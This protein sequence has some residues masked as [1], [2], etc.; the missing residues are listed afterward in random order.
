MNRSARIATGG[1]AAAAG[2]IAVTTLASR[3]VGFGRWLVFSSQTGATGVG[4]AYATANQLPNVLYE[5]AAGGALAAVAVPLIARHLNR[6]DERSADATAS[7]LLTWALT[8]LVPL[9]LLLGLAAGPL[10]RVLLSSPQGPTAATRELATMMLVVF[11]PQVALYGI[12]VVFSGILQAHRRFFAAALAPLLS[13]LVVIAAYLLYGRLSAGHNGDPATVPD[14]AAYTLAVGTTLG[15]VA[16]SLPLLIPLR[17]LG[18][19]LRPTWRFPAGVG[20]RA[21]VLAAAGLLAL[22]GQQVAVLVTVWVSNRYGDTG[23]LNVYTY[24]QAVYLLPYGVLAVPLAM[25]AFPRLAADSPASPQHAGAAAERGD[26]GGTP[27]PDLPAETLARSLRALVVAAALGAAVL[28][29]TSGP[30]GAFFRVLDRGRANS[31]SLNALEAMPAALVAYAPGLV[32][33]GTAAL[34][35]RALYVRGRPL[36]AASAVAL[37]WAVA[38]AGPLLLLSGDPGAR[39]T[40]TTLGWSSSAGMTLAGVLLWVLVVRGWGLQATA[41][42]GRAVLAALTGAGL[43]AVTGLTLGA[44]WNPEGLL[45]ALLAG[46]VLAG[47]AVLVCLAAVALVDP[48][49]YRLTTGRLL[50]R[51][52]KGR[53]RG[54]DS[55]P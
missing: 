42:A 26:A 48:A 7:A 13:S 3:L 1:I 22:L 10:S 18:V 19:R 24:V 6:G 44:W 31:E 4:E 20:R 33:W 16:L 17:R 5:V 2:V 21:G 32:G 30:V 11:A 38:A 29:A 23:T 45:P 12:G 34:L 40:L 15:V 8:V 27:A 28:V 39:T 52:G 25:S 54:R 36:L 50:S 43:A 53:S 9:S 51:L 41:G 47:V 46:L 35:T 37:G 55:A 49:T 14:A